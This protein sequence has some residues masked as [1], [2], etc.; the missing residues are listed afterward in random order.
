MVFVVVDL[1][2]NF[3]FSDPW[4]NG[5]RVLL[6]RSIFGAWTLVVTLIIMAVMAVTTVTWDGPG[7]ET[8]ERTSTAPP[9]QKLGS[10]HERKLPSQMALQRYVI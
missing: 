5:W 4:R 10:A 6:R 8:R 2:S 7:G 1:A 3:D 9:A